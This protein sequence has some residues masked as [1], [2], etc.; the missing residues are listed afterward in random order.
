MLL[1]FGR[2]PTG[3]NA[4]DHR[5]DWQQA[6][7]A[8]ID[9]ALQ[10]ALARPTGGWYVLGASHNLKR[11]QAHTVAGQE[12]VVW[13]GPNG[14]LAAPAACPHMGADLTCAEVKRGNLIC[15]WHGLALGERGHGRWRTFKTYDDGV[16]LWVRL[17]EAGEQP[18]DAP[19]IAPRPTSYISGVIRVDATCE[20]EDVIA[21]RLDPWH[22]VHYHPHS[23][24]RL[25]ILDADEDVLTLRVSYRVIGPLAMEV[26][27]TFHSPEPRTI[28]MTIV[29]GEGIGSVVETHATPIGPQ[30]TAVIEATIATSDRVGFLGARLAQ[31]FLRPMIEKRARRLWVEDAAYAERRFELRQKPKSPL[32]V[33]PS[34]DAS[35]ID[36]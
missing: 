23:F 29:A 17:P 27:A 25:V 28:T 12:L 13:R 10:R 8:K 35:G 18:T 19:I 31:D 32:Q 36:P 30:R 14:P 2:R 6:N 3:R 9:R 22:G 34:L 21:N 24:A 7:P 16:L 15:P 1:H 26:D 20:P 33:V 5:P 4:H 11:P